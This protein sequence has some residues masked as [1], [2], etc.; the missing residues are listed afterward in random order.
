M[1]ET[2]TFRQQEKGLN[3]SHVQLF[4]TFP[5]LL[6]VFFMVVLLS[7]LDFVV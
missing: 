7:R 3:P 1:E 5:I 2:M 6:V 4:V